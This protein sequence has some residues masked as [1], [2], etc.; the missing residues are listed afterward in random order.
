MSEYSVC[1]EVGSVLTKEWRDM[2]SLSELIDEEPIYCLENYTE[3]AVMVAPV[4]NAD[5]LSY[6]KSDL[7]AL[8]VSWLGYNLHKVFNLACRL[9]GLKYANHSL[10]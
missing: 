5:S 3:T 9:N 7:V 4:L 8:I 10:L 6:S 2:T 1:F